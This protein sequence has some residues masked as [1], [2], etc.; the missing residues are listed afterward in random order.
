MQG[1]NKDLN[2]ETLVPALLSVS[3]DDDR[4]AAARELLD[5]WD[6]QAHMD[7]APAALFNVFWNHLLDWTFSDQLPESEWPSGDSRWVNVVGALVGQPDNAWW[8]DLETAGVE[9]RDD[10]FRLALASAVAELEQTLGDDP[11]GWTWGDLH[12]VTFH[13]G[14]LGQS[15]IAPVEALFNRGP[16]RTSGGAS[17]VNATRWDPRRGYE[18]RSLPSMRMI[19]DLG[20]LPASLTVFTTGQSGHAF[21]EHYADMVDLWRNTSYYPMLWDRQAVEAQAESHLRLLP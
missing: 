5:G 20:D 7:S 4:L 11:Q 12:T 14:S 9:T 16:F 2:A 8:D 1:D 3:L 21:Q 19:V 17:I 18:V 6:Y 13:N 10:M 15:G